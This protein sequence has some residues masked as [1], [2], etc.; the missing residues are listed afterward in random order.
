MPEAVAGSAIAA[1]APALCGQFMATDT[2]RL[3]RVYG[4]RPTIAEDVQPLA[5]ESKV[6]WVAALRVVANRVVYLREATCFYSAW[7]RTNLPCIH[8]PMDAFRAAPKPSD[9]VDGVAWASPNPATRLLYRDAL[10]QA[11]V[12]P[13]CQAIDRK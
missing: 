13:R 7:N 10:E 4:R 8:H 6:G 9:R 2:V 1:T 11:L 5:Y 3:E 12:F